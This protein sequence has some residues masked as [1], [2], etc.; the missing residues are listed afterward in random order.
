MNAGRSVLSSGASDHIG[1]LYLFGKETHGAFEQTPKE[2]PE[3]ER[4][5]DV[6]RELQ[7]V[8]PFGILVHILRRPSPTGLHAARR[9][10]PP[11]VPPVR[12]IRL[13]PVQMP[14]CMD[15]YDKMKYKPAKLTKKTLVW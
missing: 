9:P 5:R 12:R 10:R 2:Q 11:S 13:D 6:C 1:F 3:D 4:D 8:D 14:I 15:L 7:Q